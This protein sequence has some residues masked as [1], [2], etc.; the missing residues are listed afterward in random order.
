MG[1][2]H[3]MVSMN[4]VPLVNEKCVEDFLYNTIIKLRKNH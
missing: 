4:N 3:E 1:W 2:F